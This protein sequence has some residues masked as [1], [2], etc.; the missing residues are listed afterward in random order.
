M[1]CPLS[2]TTFE[3]FAAGALCRE[4]SQDA[5]RA[6]V[7]KLGRGTPV[8]K[9]HDLAEIARLGAISAPAPVLEDR[10]PGLGSVPSI[11]QLRELR[12][13]AKE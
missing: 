3:V 1:L 7:E 9:A 10:V 2:S 6:G 5:T 12:A 13:A 11:D 4:A 8:A